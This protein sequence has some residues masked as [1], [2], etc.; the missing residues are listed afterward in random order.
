MVRDP[1][2]IM[3][4]IN[5]GQPRRDGAKPKM[6]TAK[7]HMKIRL[8]EIVRLFRMCTSHYT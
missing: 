7:D 1:S 2:G 5:V 4:G 3:V 6:L 8:N